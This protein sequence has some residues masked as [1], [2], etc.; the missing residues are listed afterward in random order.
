MKTIILFIPL[1]ISGCYL[2]NGPPSQY[3]FWA[4]PQATIEEARKDWK[5]CG[6]Q[7]SSDFSE[8]DKAL[9]Q[10]GETNWEDLY[11]RKQ[12][13]KRYSDLINKKDAHFRNCIYQLGYRFKAPISWCLAHI[14]D[15]IDICM[16][17]MKYRD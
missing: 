8:S 10:Q 9:L 17:N 13:Y 11:S 5:F 3:E 15:N 1:L 14:G 4:K 16:E 6:K 12:D 2:A 7:S